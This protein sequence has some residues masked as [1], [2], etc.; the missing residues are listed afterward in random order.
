VKPLNIFQSQNSLLPGKPTEKKTWFEL[1]LEKNE[2]DDD[3]TT[4]TTTTTN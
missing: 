1:E 4:T 2:D 3:K